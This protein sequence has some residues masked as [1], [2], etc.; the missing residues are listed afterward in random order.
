MPCSASIEIRWRNAAHYLTIC[1]ALPFVATPPRLAATHD[2]ASQ[3][4]ESGS[5]AGFSGNTSF[6][7]AL[8]RWFSPV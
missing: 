7:R 8:W 4:N 5:P 1:I 6:P 2:N 3:G